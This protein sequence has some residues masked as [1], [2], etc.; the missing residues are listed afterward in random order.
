MVINET[1][2]LLIAV[3]LQVVKMPEVVLW[4]IFWQLAIWKEKEQ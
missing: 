3:I 4:F 1:P 2:G